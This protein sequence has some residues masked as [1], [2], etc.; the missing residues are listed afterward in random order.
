MLR[1]FVRVVCLLLAMSMLTGCI[2]EPA[3]YWHDG[4]HHG[5]HHD[6]DD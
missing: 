1:S 4:W 5:W 6:D 3:G 2:V